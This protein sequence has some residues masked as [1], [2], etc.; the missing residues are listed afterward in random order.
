MGLRVNTDFMSPGFTSGMRIEPPPPLGRRKKRETEQLYD[1]SIQQ[2]KEMLGNPPPSHQDSSAGVVQGS[3]NKENPMGMAMPHPPANTEGLQPIIKGEEDEQPGENLRRKYLKKGQYG[4]IHSD[5]DK[6]MYVV[7]LITNGFIPKLLGTLGLSAPNYDIK[8]TVFNTIHDGGLT[9][10][11]FQII[12]TDLV[13]GLLHAKYGDE[14]HVDIEHPKIKKLI[15]DIS[16]YIW[17]DIKRKT[18]QQSGSGDKKQ[19]AISWTKLQKQFNDAAYIRKKKTLHS[20]VPTSTF[21]HPLDEGYGT[22]SE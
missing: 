5:H 21:T 22:D 1:K 10:R 6:Y 12:A 13:V 20:A 19:T 14:V 9:F 7:H 8:T 16:L 11:T 17:Q 2:P 15:Q 4:W 3:E 18:G